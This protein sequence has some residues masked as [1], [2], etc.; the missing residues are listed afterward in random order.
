MTCVC[1]VEWIL[2]CEALMSGVSVLST[3]VYEVKKNVNQ[4]KL[5]IYYVRFGIN[6]PWLY[7]SRFRNL[8]LTSDSRV[9]ILNQSHT[10]TVN[11]VSKVLLTFKKELEPTYCFVFLFFK[12]LVN[13]KVKWSAVIVCEI[14][15]FGVLHRPLFFVVT[16]VRKT[17]K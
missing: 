4:V 11:Q 12:I 16:F 17:R 2:S 6:G 8:E 5:Q 13:D 1:A 15:I 3:C 7:V 10:L 14:F 9:W